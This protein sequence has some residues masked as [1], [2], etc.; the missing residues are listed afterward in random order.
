[1]KNETMEA[2]RKVALSVRTLTMDAVQKANSGHPGL[3]MGCAELGAV[4]FGEVLRHNPATPDWVNRDRFVLSAGHGSMLL[5]CL[6]HLSGYDLSLEELKNFRQLGSKTPGHPE[7]GV[8]VGVETTTGPLG[9]GLANAVGMAIAET[10]LADRF[11]TK[12]HTIIDHYTYALAGDGCMMEGVTSE[13]ASLAGH[14]GLG[15]LI[16]FYDSNKITIDGSTDITFTEDVTRRYQA[17]GWQT[18]SGSAYDIGEIVGLIEQAKAETQ[19]PTLIVLTSVIA[20]GSP[21]LAGSHKAHGAPLGEEEVALTKKALGVPETAMFYIDPQAK[22]YFGQKQIVW[23]EQQKQWQQEYTE[24]RQANPEL[25]KLW[26]RFFAEDEPAD[27]KLPD[28]KVGDAIATRS[29]GHE[30]LNATAQGMP[31][32]IGGSADLAGSNKTDLK[33]LGEYQKTNHSGRNICFGV[34]EHGMGAVTNGLALHGG[35]RVFCATFLVFSDYMRP[36]IRLAALMKLP[37]IYIFTH[38]SIFVGEDGPTH[39]P[40]EQ[41]AA[42]RIIPDLLVFRPADAQEHVELWKLVCGYKDGPIAMAL[43]RQNLAVF[44]KQDPDWKKQIKRGAYIV[45]DCAGTPDLIL[46]ASGSEVGLAL[47]VAAQLED[48][49]IRV[50]SMPCRELFL[51]QPAARQNE[52][53]PPEVTKAVIEA[54]VTFGWQD[55]IKGKGMVFGIDRFGESGPGK[56]V[57]EYLGLKVTKIAAD[58]KQIT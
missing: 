8:T 53:L 44:E 11:N 55:I 33:G 46:I 29:S 17:Y 37:V 16:V 20:K 10:I 21:H 48:K 28:Y 43:S 39:Q 40:V 30:I 47:Q 22:D 50:V 7:H 52:L 2:I 56:S 54:G 57:A 25:Y 14:L 5:Y 31:Y 3:P 18:L 24:W 9:Q 19:R 12:D 13:A 49:K 26:Q 45:K 36:P 4:L 42:L 34:R 35:L 23:A 41:L 15:K 32:L 38:D 51:Q 6:L 58:L 27:L 1:M